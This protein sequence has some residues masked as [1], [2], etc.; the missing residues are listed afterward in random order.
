VIRGYLGLAGRSLAAHRRRAAA[1]VASVALSVGLVVAVF[2]MIDILARFERSEV[3]RKEGSYHILVR[4]A[5]AA[6]ARAIAARPEV[7]NSGYLLDLGKGTAASRPC[8]FASVDEGIAGS[9]VFRLASGRYPRASDEVMVEDWSLRE[10]KIALGEP[11]ELAL[12]SGARVSALVVGRIADLGATKAAGI[13]AVFLSP[14]LAASLPRAS[15]DYFI[16]FKRGTDPIRAEASLA[17]F[18]GLSDSRIGRNEGLLALSLHSKNS[19]VLKLYAIG[20]FL[21]L[22]VLVTAVVMISNVLNISVLERSR[23][24]GL[25]RCLGASPAQ[26]RRLVRREGLAIAGIG[27]PAGIALGEFFTLGCALFLKYVDGEIFGGIEG[28]A[29]SLGGVLAG[30]ALGFLSVMIASRKPASLASRVSP[31]SAL[32]GSERTAAARGRRRL[33]FLPIEISLGANNALGRKKSFILMSASMALGVALFLGFSVLVNPTFLGI[34]TTRAYTADLSLRSPEGFPGEAVSRIAAQ[35]GVAAVWGRKSAFVDASFDAST[36]APAYL[37]LARR[38]GKPVQSSGG[39]SRPGRSRLLSYDARQFSWARA[40]IAEGRADEEAFNAGRGVI[41]VRKTWR[42]EDGGLAPSLAPRIGD[43][44]R[45]ESAGGEELFT[46]MAIADSIPYS[47][48]EESFTTLVTTEALFDSLRGP[49][50]Y[51]ELDLRL[52]GAKPDTAVCAVKDA[53]GASAIMGDRRQYNAEADRAFLTA[54]LF[55]YGFVVVIGLIAALNA[56]NTMNTSV[57]SRTR[58]FAALRAIGLSAAQLRRMVSAEAGL[59]CACGL[60]A[61]ALAGLGLQKV[62]LDFLRAPWPFPFAALGAAL[63]FSS[64]AV[65]F[66]VRGPLRRL[67]T[68]SVPEALSSL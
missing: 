18:L 39:L 6:E 60:G 7:E 67:E 17:S 19:R 37:D 59:Y 33:A 28:F 34:R 29:F 27:V 45:V 65:A 3:E 43:R 40:Y 64:C 16:R 51:A 20:G 4:N 57:A 56:A 49:A 38:A 35:K 53:A 22:L 46:V 8:A 55:I 66:S 44:I 68:M 62:I 15:A 12:P 48:D 5:G 30:V 26:I 31:L 54:A 21:F 23:Q 2:S 25:L 52:S 50:P 1:A 11:V 47:V 41:A 63:V 42:A 13:S 24:Y 10:W 32:K 9:L 58:Y 14:A 36:I 61:G